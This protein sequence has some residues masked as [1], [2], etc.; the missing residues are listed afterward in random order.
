MTSCDLFSEVEFSDNEDEDDLPN[1]R[2]AWFNEDGNTYKVTVR[3][4]SKAMY[5]GETPSTNLSK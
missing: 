4:E 5:G 1:W 2:G 3:H